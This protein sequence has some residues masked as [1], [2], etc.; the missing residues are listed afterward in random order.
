[1]PPRIRPG[2]YGAVLVVKGTYAGRVGY[3][4]DDEEGLAIVYFDEP[5]MSPYVMLRHSWLRKTT[6]TPLVLEKW[7]RKYPE[8]ADHFDVP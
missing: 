8:I 2:E 4:D 3:Y 6:V 1:M 7:K 5:L